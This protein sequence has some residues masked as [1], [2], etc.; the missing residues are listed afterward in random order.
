MARKN[1]FRSITEEESRAAERQ[2]AKRNE[3]AYAA[4]ADSIKKGYSGYQEA[5]K[6]AAQKRSSTV[7]TN[8]YAQDPEAYTNASRI[9]ENSLNRGVIGVTPK[10][11]FDTTGKSKKS[12][13]QSNYKVNNG[14]SV[15]QGPI[16]N[17]NAM[18]QLGNGSSR[19]P[20]SSALR[21]VQRAD[22]SID[23]YRNENYVPQRSQ[24]IV[25]VS[26]GTDNLNE[27]DR[28]L[29]DEYLTSA[30][31]APNFFQKV[32]RGVESGLVNVSNSVAKTLDMVGSLGDSE[33]GPLQELWYM[34]GGDA[35]TGIKD[36]PIRQYANLG[37]ET[38]NSIA[39]RDRNIQNSNTYKWSSGVAQ[40]LPLMAMS[41]LSAGLAAAGTATT[42]GV[43]AASRLGLSG[44]GL[45]QIGE[46]ARQSISAF[47]KRPDAIATFSTVLGPTYNEAKADGAD[48]LHAT[49]YAVL[50]SIGNTIVELGGVDVNLGGLQS[51]PQWVRGA[52][53]RGE[54]SAI[55]NYV[56]SIGEEPC[57]E[58]LQGILERGLKSIYKDV[59]LYDKNDEDSIINPSAMKEEATNA[60]AI[61]AILGV[62]SLGINTAWNISDRRSAAKANAAETTANTANPVIEM[63]NNLAQNINVPVETVSRVYNLSPDA[64]PNAFESA[65]QAA[66]TM[67]QEGANESALSNVPTLTPAQASIAYSM[68]RSAITENVA[69]PAAENVTADIDSAVN[70]APENIQ[71]GNHEVHLR[72][73]S[74]WNDSENTGRPIRELEE[75]A[76]ADTAG[77]AQA[78]PE[79]QRGDTLKAGKEI[80]YNGV[81][82]KGVHRV[83]G[84]N[85]DTRKARSLAKERGYKVTFFKDGNIKVSKGEARALVDSENKTIYVRADHPE[86]TATQLMRHE[87][88]HDAIKGGEIKLDD[89]RTTLNENFTPEQIDSMADRY[90]AAYV[91]ADGKPVLNADEAF[92]EI[93]CDA[94]GGMN[95][96]ENTGE[97]PEGYQTALDTIRE[98]TETKGIQSRAPPRNSLTAAYGSSGTTYT[99][100]GESVPFRY[101]VIP[102]ESLVTSNDA[103]G[104]V[105]PRYP[106]ELQPRD[107]TRGSSQLQID[108]IARSLNPELLAESPTAQNGAPIVR[109]DGVVIGGN[110]R[111]TAI[112]RAYERGRADS[113]R[114][115]IE[116]NAEKFGIDEELPEHPVLVRVVENSDNWSDLAKTLNESSMQSYS[117]TE[118]AMADADRM[119]DILSLLRYDEDTGNINVPANSAFIREFVS[120]VASSNERN[121]LVTKDGLLSQTGLERA[122]NAIFAKAYNDANL[123]EKL[124]ESLDNDMKNVTNAMLAVA[125]RGAELRTDIDNGTAYDID[126]TKDILDG[127][128]LYSDAKQQGWTIEEWQNQSRLFG[129]Y[130]EEAQRIAQF[131]EDNRRSSKKLREFFGDMYSEVEKLGDPNQESLFGT[132]DVSRSEILD[133]A[134]NTYNA[135]HDTNFSL[136]SP[137][138][139]ELRRRNEQILASAATEDTVN[140]NERGL[141]DSFKK[142][143]EKVQTLNEQLEEQRQAIETAEAS[144]DESGLAAA[145]NREGILSNQYANARR[146]L[147]QI[148]STPA[149]ETLR[150]RIGEQWA[151]QSTDTHTVSRQ[152][153]ENLQ[154][155]QGREPLN[156]PKESMLGG[157]T[158]RHVQTLANSGVTPEAF[159][160]ALRNDAALGRFDHIRYTDDAAR[161]RAEDKINQVG[162]DRALAEFENEVAAGK[163]SK[164]ITTLGITL[165]NNAVTKGDYATAMD[166][167]TSLVKNSTNTAQSMQAMSILNKMSPECRLYAVAKGV[168]DVQEELN[169]RYKD[170][171]VNIEVDE[172]LYKDYLDALK[173]GDQDAIDDATAKI[174]QSIAQ[175]IPATWQEKVNAWRY[176]AMLANTRTH[177][178]NIVGNAGFVPVRGIKDTLAYAIESAANKVTGGKVG[179]TQSILNLSNANDKALLTY[180]LNDYAAVENA[181]MGSKW[182]SSFS[183]I[184]NYRTI[185]KA[186]LLEAV[187][188]GNSKALD[189]EDSWF[190]EPAYANAL[191]RYYKANGVTAEMLN[192]N[193][194]S[195]QLMIN[196]QAWAIREAQEATYRDTNWFSSAVNKI[197]RTRAKTVAG[198]GVNILLEGLLPFK[199]TPA[200]I[201]AR[202]VE[203]SPVGLLKTLSADTVKLRK[204]VKGQE[205]GISPNDYINNLSKGLTGT[206]LTGLGML[207]ASWAVL[208][209]SEDDDKQKDF[210]GLLGKQNYA[211]NVGGMSIT[212]DWLAPESMP[213]FVGVELYNNLAK[214]G[215]SGR[216]LEDAISSVMSLANP[217]FEMSMVQSVNDVLEDLQYIKEGQGLYRI[218]CSLAESYIS[219]Y[220]PTL[221]GQAERTFTE[222]QR[223]TTYIDRNG[224]LGN[225]AQYLLGTIGNK[226]PF[227]D[228]QQI[229][230]INA[231]GQTESTGNMATRAFNN[232][233]NPAYTKRI[234]DDAVDQELERLYK[235]GESKVYPQRPKAG[236]KIYDTP[237]TADQYVYYATTKGQKSREYVEGIMGSS[238][239]KNASDSEKA[240]MISDAYGFADRE[241]Q[242][243]LGY[244]TR[245]K[246]QREGEG[247]PVQAIIDHTLEQ[248]P[249]R[250]DSTAEK[251]QKA[252]D[253]LALIQT[254]E[255]KRRMQDA[256]K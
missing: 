186:K 54:K 22:G 44:G 52:L 150:N 253:Y 90:A 15:G 23:V 88:T 213:L 55:W 166:I 226:I 243:G 2:I 218:T 227:V 48:D 128:R 119:G 112:V 251:K 202:A 181:I 20:N 1:Q 188:K 173:N 40:T 102:A 79:V 78:R 56:K 203:Y 96:F 200:N 176:M 157:L 162:W 10:T 37:R 195:D 86:F 118:Q 137:R 72:Q 170:N 16:S 51:L 121:A 145:R 255:Y 165:Y 29:Y 97:M 84:S 217:M 229:P 66:Y 234:Q 63:Q 252:D 62:P 30:M 120:G 134:V 131:I 5:D 73:G 18:S 60:A 153:A 25:D 80:S 201:L 24:R 238:A 83:V 194:V 147:N 167:V 146:K 126:V 254:D 207:L 113:Y 231:W 85:E 143:F 41:A 91:T 155:Q 130:S 144:G 17:S 245:A 31:E 206:M 196:A 34:L 151:E 21:G 101:A 135:E 193:Q 81:T 210:N 192:T 107:R 93:V 68:G 116:D 221:F 222:N 215:G 148:M 249:K 179:R 99:G 125:P 133:R 53:A 232:M 49:V 187:R 132:E 185:Y 45:A 65:F 211:L 180:A 235:L 71:E 230:Y 64:D 236:T 225:E 216:K 58:L 160:D 115:Y 129:D 106:A 182:N 209:G 61:A 228:Y 184:D 76:G 246:W 219:Q 12:G 89:V 75:G 14:I 189:K 138:L 92:E 59:P 208:S 172:Q 212:L 39:Q 124:S 109:D 3:E 13:Q 241:A 223:E 28:Q 248:Y 174:E 77:Q 169:R 140:A 33:G 26:E 32:G 46:I 224:Q 122:Q 171:N 4:K 149:L 175:Q 256:I 19:I 239:Y 114:Q 233:V 8:L 35:I 197:G 247:N 240:Y 161:Q 156:L 158:S 103:E 108:R 141:L 152:Q 82:Q 87:L 204:Y 168:Q 127:V 9:L 205:G 42:A 142:Q 110:G 67:G 98:N 69:Q 154:A 190:C 242:A 123:S 177:V 50:N 38:V 95:V 237:L 105:N 36:N 104:R 220:F 191:A 47:A 198:K 183:G 7:N 250:E 11:V 74:E 244:D 139:Q 100:E 164:D 6:R 159:S 70:I 136:D 117:A 214:G 178:R 94:M 27:N 163:T 111:G 57:E 43:E 199:K